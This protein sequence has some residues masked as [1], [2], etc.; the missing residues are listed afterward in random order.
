MATVIMCYGPA[1]HTAADT[2]MDFGVCNI[3]YMT[4]GTSHTRNGAHDLQF[5]FQNWCLEIVI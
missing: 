4:V 3:F 2:K 1:N 5:L